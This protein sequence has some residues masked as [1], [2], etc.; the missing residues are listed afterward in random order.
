MKAKGIWQ[1]VAAVALGFLVLPGVVSAN[2]GKDSGD[3]VDKR[4]EHLKEKLSLT[5]DQTQKVRAIL[6]SAKAANEA[7]RAAMQQRKEQTD[8]QIL[9]VLNEEQKAK[10][11]KIQEKRKE[12]WQERKEKGNRGWWHKKEN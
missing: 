10:Y 5:D 7:A 11:T 12:K 2:E 9:A 3:H 8:Q 6:E 4:V 1:L